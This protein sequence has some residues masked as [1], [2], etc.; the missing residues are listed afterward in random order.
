MSK[1][2]L[3]EQE[4]DE[5]LEKYHLLSWKEL[6]L[7]VL[8]KNEQKEKE[9]RE[10]LYSTNVTNDITRIIEITEALKETEAA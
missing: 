3:I 9:H 4:L 7:E 6:V 5:I 1:N 8:S 2:E 10:E